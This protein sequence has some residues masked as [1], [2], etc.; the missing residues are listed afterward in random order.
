MI[1]LVENKDI[2]QICNIYNF[3]VK[4]STA[5]FEE[6]EVSL[7][8]MKNR[9]EE[10]SKDLPYFVYEENNE[11]LGYSYGSKWKKRSAYKYT[12]ETSVYLKN[13]CISKGLGTKL[14]SYLLEE[15]K[16]RGIHSIIGGISLP[17]EKS[18]KLHEKLGFKKVAH[19]N[20][21][22]YKFDNW[23]DV[24]YWQLIIEKNL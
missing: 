6:E 17:N 8:E 19:F 14:Y 7:N 13:D 16:K 15:L 2:E 4:N 18:Q 22:G 23:I 24:G 10:L 1:R 5:T 12:V 21:M 9:V 11:I 3:Y 20:Q